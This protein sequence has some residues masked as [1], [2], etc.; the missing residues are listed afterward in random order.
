MPT[1][2]HIRIVKLRKWF[3]PH[4]ALAA[5][6]ARLCILR[7]DL[8][9]EMHGVYT[10]EIHE[11]DQHSAEFRRMYFLRNLVRT[12]MEV[13]GA[14]QTLLNS[15]EFGDLLA[16]APK[17]TQDL[18]SEAA[19]II[20]KAHPIAKEVRNDI[21]GHVLEK[22]VQEALERMDPDSWG[23][24]EVGKILK[25]THYKFAGEVTAEILLKGVTKEERRK[26]E[27]SKFAMIADLVPIFSLIDHC[28]LMYLE[29]RKL[30]P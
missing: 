19:S 20:G 17:K 12:L 9:L 15:R 18:F 3:P 1:A 2:L 10:E 26:I 8:L 6:I 13:S 25:T 28:L 30:L 24:F 5:K 27:S 22:A 4:D 23:F 29:D 11:L 21:C 16:K 7:E 14:M